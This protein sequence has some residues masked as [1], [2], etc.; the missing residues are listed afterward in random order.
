ML[1]RKER[2]GDIAL[3]G[4]CHI[5]KGRTLFNSKGKT[6]RPASGEETRCF[7]FLII[8]EDVIW[9]WQ[10]YDWGFLGSTSRGLICRLLQ[11][12]NVAALSSVAAH[13]EGGLQSTRHTREDGEAGDGSHIADSLVGLQGTKEAGMRRRRK[14][15]HETSGPNVT[16]FRRN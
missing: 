15:T 10:L 14:N 13:L 5:R 8:A 4:D 6:A 2:G 7:P 11:N 12:L 3:R 9:A 16:A 1:R